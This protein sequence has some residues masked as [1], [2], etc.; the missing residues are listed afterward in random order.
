M[1]LWIHKLSV[2]AELRRVHPFNIAVMAAISSTSF[3]G[4]IL[5]GRIVPVSIPGGRADLS[6]PRGRQRGRPSQRGSGI[7]RVCAP[8][9][10]GR[11]LSDFARGRADLGSLA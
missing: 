8:G 7:A 10:T 3:G 1:D 2:S 9:Q 5:T 11:S 6:T 4:E